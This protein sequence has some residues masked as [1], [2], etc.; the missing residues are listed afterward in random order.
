MDNASAGKSPSVKTRDTEKDGADGGGKPMSKRVCVV[1]TI[2]RITLRNL[3][4]WEDENRKSW[5][6]W[7]GPG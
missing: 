4:A 2:W 7:M 3:V 5:L 1:K 6:M